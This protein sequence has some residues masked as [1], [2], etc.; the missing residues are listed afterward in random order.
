M[1]MKIGILGGGMVAQAIGGKLQAL[2]HDVMIGIRNPDAGELEKPRNGGK[3]L[4]EWAAT[5]GAKVGTLSATAAHGELLFNC[6]QGNGSIP[7]LKSAGA[8]AI[9][10]KILVDVANPLDFSKG[11]PPSLL[12][13]FAHGTSLGEEIQK[14]L[15]NA[16]VVKAFNTIANAV[17]VDA[18]LVPG[19][20]DLLIAGNDAAAKAEVSALAKSFGWA[21]IV[22]L[23]DIVGARST[24]H[25]L[26]IWIRLWATSGSA[27]HNIKIVR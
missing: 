14:L 4:K 27:M 26:P 6:T 5:T 1:N 10:S 13:E 22:D 2:G 15:P 3:P 19:D 24:E 9:G 12:P 21:S 11:M 17:M 25:L 23:G 8:D 18:S 7:A 20:H 16:R